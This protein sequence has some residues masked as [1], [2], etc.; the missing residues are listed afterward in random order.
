MD[1]GAWQATVHR[2]T[3]SQTQVKQQHAHALDIIV[4]LR[5]SSKSLP[6]QEYQEDEV[7]A[8]LEHLLHNWPSV[9]C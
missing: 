5:F 2:V 6:S 4:I 3:K 7:C 8:F 1:R 9:L